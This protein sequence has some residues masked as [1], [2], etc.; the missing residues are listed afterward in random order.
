MA[1]VKR[2]APAESVVVP[3]IAP[4]LPSP[5]AFGSPQYLLLQ[6]LGNGS[7]GVAYVAVR[8]RDCNLAAQPGA[9]MPSCAE[10]FKSNAPLFVVKRF[11]KELDAEEEHGK[12]EEE[13]K[14]LVSTKAEMFNAE[15]RSAAWIK[16]AIGKE[17]NLLYYYH[18][19]SDPETG[20]DAMVFE[21]CNCGDIRRLVSGCKDGSGKLIHLTLFE[22]LSIGVQLAEGLSV[23]HEHKIVHRDLALRN[24]FV[25]YDSKRPN[26]LT[27][28]IGGVLV[29]CLFVCF[30]ACL[31]IYVFGCLQI[32]GCVW[33]SATN[34]CRAT[35]RKTAFARPPRSTTCTLTMKNQMSTR[36]D[37]C[38]MVCVSGCCR[39]FLILCR[40]AVV[41]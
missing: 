31:F 21:F 9:P 35:R 2:P 18:D 24:L 32:L 26:D 23:L 4:F 37:S 36:W 7:F 3:P 33:T 11:R 17:S 15:R 6:K 29:V 10:L 38:S 34:R 16:E 41:G 20:V 8:A 22:I 14:K 27:I 39:W 12:T 25:H 30:F 1:E 5:I 28:K 13:K 40:A 19:I